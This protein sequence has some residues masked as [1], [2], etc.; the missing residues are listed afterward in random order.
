ME[1]AVIKVGGKQYR[2]SKGDVIDVDRLAADK[3]GTVELKDVLM[4]VSDGK[5]NVG[6]PKV[7]S[8]SVKAKVLEEKKGKK[9]RVSKFKAKVRYRR[10]IGFRP[11]LTRLQ[12]T[13]IGKVS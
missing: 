8:L 9:I 10:V 7:Q 3:N 13:D 12:I 6:K 2:V 11:F 5:V 1:Y 4:Y